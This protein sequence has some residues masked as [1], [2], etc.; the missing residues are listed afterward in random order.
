MLLLKNRVLILVGCIALLMFSGCNAQNVFSI[1]S[2]NWMV[3]EM[4][5]G[6]IGSRYSNEGISVNEV[7]IAI[8][9]P[10]DIKVP[11]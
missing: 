5:F 4:D 2:L 1:A 9:T 10:T 11:K 3:L 7:I 8:N 6:F